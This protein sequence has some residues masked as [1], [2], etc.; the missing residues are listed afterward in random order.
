MEQNDIEI[1]LSEPQTAV[2]DTRQAVTLQMAGQ[3]GG[4]SQII[5]Y[6]SA[7]FILDFPKIK[8]FIGANTEKQLTQST[9]FV[10]FKVWEEK[11]GLTE[12][13]KRTNPAGAF[14]IDKRPPAHFKKFHKFR[15]YHGVVSFWNGCSVFL[16]SLENYLAHDGK[17]FGWAHLDETKDTKEEALKGVIVARLR[18]YGLWYHKDT[19][20]TIFD[21]TVRE[22]ESIAKGWIS[23]NPLYIHTSPS[24]GGVEWL[25]KMFK[26]E[27]FAKEIKT[28]VQ[29]KE[30]DYFFREFENKCVVIYSAYHN[31]HNLPPTYLPGQEA[32]L[33]TED[34]ILKFVHGYP[35]SKSGSEYFPFFRRDKH[36][37]HVPYVPGLPVHM[38]WDFNVVPYMTCLCA[39]VR[40]ITRYRDEVGNKYDEP[41]YGYVPIEILRISFYKEYCLGSPFDS[42]EG[43]C[44]HFKADHDPQNTEV[45]YYGDGSGLSR[46]PGLGSYTNFGSISEKLFEYVNKSSKRV[47]FPNVAPLTRRD[48]VNKIL[49]GPDRVITAAEIEVEIEIDESMEKTIGDMEHVKQGANGKIKES[50]EDPNTK[51]K[52]EK[53]GHTSDA[54]EYMVAW[55]CKEYL[56][57]Y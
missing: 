26:L 1:E 27:P 56:Q 53:N 54:L 44:E 41:A 52:Y 51:K 20:D 46:I 13:D 42:V 39:H 57:D 49:K 33:V 19:K 22:E 7:M 24:L 4:K 29:R 3:G 9:L 8:G 25:N 38:S 15:N 35:F 28:R 34:A 21:E 17:E 47:K 5:G 37:K 2:M 6:S 14:V 31:K 55:I 11:F 36:V 40:Y 16:G 23:W 43:V 48:M 45:F 10:V 50:V 18:Q 12:Y 32:N 30:K